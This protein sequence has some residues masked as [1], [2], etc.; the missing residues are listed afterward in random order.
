MTCSRQNGHGLFDIDTETGRVIVP[1]KDLL[2][3]R[4]ISSVI[5]H[6]LIMFFIDEFTHSSHDVNV[7]WLLLLFLFF[8]QTANVSAEN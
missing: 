7:W 2:W 4:N 5:K 3:L 6:D 1:Y 8:I